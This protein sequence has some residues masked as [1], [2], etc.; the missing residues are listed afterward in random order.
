MKNKMSVLL[1]AAALL[2]FSAP[3][4][5]QQLYIVDMDVQV[6]HTNP[7]GYC[8][9]VQGLLNG[10]IDLGD[11]YTVAFARNGGNVWQDSAR[12]EFERPTSKPGTDYGPAGANYV[13]PNSCL[14][15]CAAIQCV[16]TSTPSTF[17]IDDMTFE[18]FKFAP[19]SNP[20]DPSSTPP[21]KT[22]SLY[23]IGTCSCT[24]PACA[25]APVQILNNTTGGAWYCA[26]WDGSYNL[27]GIFGKTNGQYGFRARVTTRQTT[28]QGTSIDIEQTS[29]YPGQNQIPI[30][31]DVTNLHMIRSSPTPVGRLTKVAAQPYNILYRLSKD[32]T[33]TISIYDT[34]ISHRGTCPNSMP[35]VRTI[36]SSQPRVGEGIPDGVLTN[37]DFWDGR[38]NKGVIVPPGS[39][40]ARIDASSNDMWGTDL[41]WP[42]TIQISLDPLQVTDVAVKPLGASSTDM[43]NISYMLTEA[44]TVYVDIYPPG[45][46]FATTNVSGAPTTSP[47]VPFL[48]RFKEQK[49]SRKTSYTYWDGRDSAGYPVCDGDYV[50]VIYAELPSSGNFNYT[51]CT[52]THAWSK[53]QTRSV[54]VGVVPVARGPVLAFMRPSSTVIG[55]SP[56][57]AGLDPFYF[58]YTP[59]RDAWVRLNIKRMTGGAGDLVRTVVGTAMDPQCS[60]KLCGEVRFANV[61]NREMWDGKDDSGNYV[62]SGAY[63][64]E[65]ITVDP[66]QCSELKTSTMTAIMPVSMFRTVDVR[67]TPLLSSSSATATI[68]FQLSQPMYSELKVYPRDT[69]IS[70]SDFPLLAGLSGITPV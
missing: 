44:A 26:A 37:G 21:I 6:D 57:A 12:I 29:A 4:L 58:R 23:N 61:V 39:Y 66:F 14:G 41:A 20:L 3:V 15:L 30:Q 60:D 54:K 2:G 25:A 55:S 24:S 68:R 8:D 32:S 13:Y 56:S 43:A 70:P 65:L 40:L 50:F 27:N 69:V 5:A 49:E 17:G 53:V 67:T 19:G 38:S 18:I 16:V 46:T 62:S 52:G 34:D 1:C 36:I 11:E 31:I 47:S 59:S 35:P 10:A 64:A 22:I 28:A 7:T 45:T 63:L 33:A 48:R 51:G 42:A 9:D